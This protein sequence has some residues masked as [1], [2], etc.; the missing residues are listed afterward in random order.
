MLRM[1][2]LVSPACFALMWAVRYESEARNNLRILPLKLIDL[3]LT[4]KIDLL[5]KAYQ[6]WIQLA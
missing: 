3:T 1:L 4:Q 6:Y 2:D 5:T